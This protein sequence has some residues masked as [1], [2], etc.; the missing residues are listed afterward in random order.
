MKYN[1]KI[2][3]LG[4]GAAF[5]TGAIV[6]Q[7][8]KKSYLDAQPY[9]QYQ[10][11]AIA[12][13]KGVD[14]LLIGVYGILDG[15][16]SPG[17][18]WEVSAVNWATAGVAADD[19]YKG[20]DA[21][22]QPQ[23]TEVEQYQSQPNNR[24]FRNKWLSVYEGVSRANGVIKLINDPATTGLTDD[25]KKVRI[26]QARF[27]R[28][29]YHFDA[30]RMWNKVPYITEASTTYDNT[31]DIWPDIEADFKFAYD[32][33]PETWGE[34]ARVN[35]WAAAAYLAKTYLWQKK[36]TEAKAMF[37]LVIANGKNSSGVKYDLQPA[38]WYNFDP[39]FDNSS[40]S[41]FAIS[42]AAS[43]SSDASGERSL[44]L[45]YPYGGDFG[46]CGFFQPSQNLVNAF[47][48]DSTTGLP[49][50]STFNDA[51]LKNDQGIKAA[52][53]GVFVNDSVTTV[54]P[55]L[56]WTV[57]RRGIYFWDWGTHPGVPWIRDQNYA[58]PFSP[59]KHIYTS[60]QVKANQVAG[61][62]NISSKDVYI[63]RYADVLLMAAEAEVEVGSLETARGY[64]NMVRDRAKNPI[65]WV[66]EVPG[67][68]S[69]KQ[70]NA[71]YVINSYSTPWVDKT[72]A[73]A[74]IRFER[75]LE[76]AEEGHRF[77]DLVRWGI[78]DQVLNA[79]IAKEKLKRNYK[80]S[81]VFVKGKNEYF[82][83][84]SSVIDLAA[85]YG[86]KLDQN[87]GY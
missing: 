47:K 86:S 14:A 13:K 72:A 63:I 54:D 22:D 41:V 61:W 58:G 40:E 43:S 73:T 83:I 82:P 39:A 9:G 45:A 69:S 71:R 48:T 67:D 53:D 78:A 70:A 24:Y 85:K 16:G 29:H 27:L 56:D 7:A 4:F 37:D 25:D 44:G 57:G 74:A 75:R 28:G 33:L 34:K 5:I 64:V 80:Q 81:A 35:K 20:T 11:T 12:N 42:S 77:F 2:K 31:K 10:Q 52:P 21:N 1:T 8:C 17:D 51:D 3:W 62:R 46:C 55:R 76:L 30:K 79:Y 36:Y 15:Q 84:P 60:A 49:L 26:A 68:L 66:R 87:P 38:F 6:L 65:S 59:K 19:A 18:S 32:N 50:I 23:M